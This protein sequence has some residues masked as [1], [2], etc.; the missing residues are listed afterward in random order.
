MTRPYSCGPDHYKKF[1]IKLIVYVESNNEAVMQNLNLRGH[2]VWL[3][4]KVYLPNLFPFVRTGYVQIT[5]AHEIYR[6]NRGQG[7]WPLFCEC[8]RAAPGIVKMMPSLAYK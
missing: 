2:K 8:L 3:P 5:H 7:I 1:T 6:L 4:L